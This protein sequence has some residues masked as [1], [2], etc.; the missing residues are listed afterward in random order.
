MLVRHL[1][2][3]ANIKLTLKHYIKLALNQC[4]VFTG[5]VTVLHI[6]ERSLLINDAQLLCILSQLRLKLYILYNC[7]I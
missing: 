2:R 5:K 3:L 6:V 1:R 7:I 4:S